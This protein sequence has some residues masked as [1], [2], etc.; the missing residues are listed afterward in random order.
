MLV[1][2]RTGGS[3]VTSARSEHSVRASA[4]RR[5]SGT[6]S[7]NASTSLSVGSVFSEDVGRAYRG[8]VDREARAVDGDA[9][10]MALGDRAHDGEAE[11]GAGGVRTGAAPEALERVLGLLGGEAG[12]LV[13]DGEA[14]AVPLAP[15]C[16]RD[17][18]LAVV[19]RVA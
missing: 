1:P 2:Q 4:R 11:A 16:H 10:L 3:P 12:A 9:A 5:S 6:A 17:P 15:G 18:A 8:E 7:R 13:G 14:G 19:A